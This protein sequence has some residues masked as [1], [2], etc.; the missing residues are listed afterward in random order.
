MLHDRGDDVLSTSTHGHCRDIVHKRNDPAQDGGCLVPLNLNNHPDARVTL[1]LA[2][3]N[4][5]KLQV[6]RS[7]VL[8]K[9]V[10]VKTPLLG[11][12]PPAI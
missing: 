9:V 8:E 2:Q 4:L 3:Q 5:S 1:G 12:L 6:L 11:A 10:L 7:E